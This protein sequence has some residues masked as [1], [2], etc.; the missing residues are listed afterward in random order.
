MAGGR[1]TDTYKQ[2]ILE[3]RV[4]TGEAIVNAFEQVLGPRKAVVRVSVELDLERAER[5]AEIAASR[6]SRWNQRLQQAA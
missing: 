4:R 3:S 1:W 6:A 5:R 2:R